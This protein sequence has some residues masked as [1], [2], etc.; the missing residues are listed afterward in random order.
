MAKFLQTGQQLAPVTDT[1]VRQLM[2]RWIIR[3]QQ[4]FRVTENDD[5]RK[6]HALGHAI[7][8]PVKLLLT[9]PNC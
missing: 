3:D 5:F 6:D 2:I 8:D 4:S 7:I 9:P 1:S